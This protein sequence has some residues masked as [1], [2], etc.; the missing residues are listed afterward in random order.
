M[1]QMESKMTQKRYR[2]A[3]FLT[4]ASVPSA[5]GMPVTECLWM[6]RSWVC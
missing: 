5:V 6:L 4:M 3:L 1:W 2:L